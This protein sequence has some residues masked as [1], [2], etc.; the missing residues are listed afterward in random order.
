MPPES[1]RTSS[2]RGARPRGRTGPGRAQ[3]TARPGGRPA[4]DQ[5][6]SVGLP[7]R[8]RPRLTGRAAVLVLVLS[9]LTI[10]YAS[11]LRAY[12]DQREHID[13]LKGQIALREAEID[14]LERE[15]R[16]WEDPAYVRQQ[17][18]DL[19]YVMP[20]ETAYVVL[21][22]DGEPLDGEATLSD[23]DAVAPRQP[24]AWWS[25]AWRSVEVAGHPPKPEKAPASKINGSGG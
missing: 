3:A 6:G 8:R 2:S 16:R 7:G 18:R 21:D 14:D 24:R 19:N 9:L 1:R 5:P 22:E 10:S 13:D 12:L 15:K 25:T 17:A 23:P 20:G 4:A 11:S